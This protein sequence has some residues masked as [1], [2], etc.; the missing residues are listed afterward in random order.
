VKKKEAPTLRELADQEL[1][2]RTLKVP[3]KILINRIVAECDRWRDEA[4]QIKPLIRAH[5]DKV[6]KLAT[7][8]RRLLR[9]QQAA[10]AKL[11]ELGADK[12]F[13]R[14]VARLRT[15]G[16]EP[17]LPMGG[18]APAVSLYATVA[19]ALTGL[20]HWEQIWRPKRGHPRELAVGFVNSLVTLCRLAGCTDE[21]CRVLLQALSESN[22]LPKLRD[23]TLKRRAERARKAATK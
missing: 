5:R 8:A 17:P 1:T 11:R 2:R 3:R 7:L 23:S 20:R 9:V 16:I 19:N 6:R 12:E 4:P 21:E 15:L 13:V 14:E 22:G 18:A 10:D